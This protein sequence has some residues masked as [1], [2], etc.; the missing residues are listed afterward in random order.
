MSWRVL[1][2][3]DFEPDAQAALRRAGLDVAYIPGIDRQAL[4]KE[5]ASA[6]VLVVRVSTPVDRA[7]LNAGAHLKIVA[8]PGSGVDHIDLRACAERGI[9]VV[10]APGANAESV[11]ELTL[12][13]MLA[14]SR[15]L[16]EALLHTAAGGWDKRLFLGAELQGKTIGLVGRGR[17]GARV[18][19]LAAA[20]GMKVLVSDPAV[21][22]SL[23][24]DELLPAADFVSVHVPLLPAT[25]HLIGAAQLARLRPGAVLMNLSRGGIVDET[26]VLDRPDIL[27]VA[28]VM[29]GEPPAGGHADPRPWPRTPHIGAWTQEAQRR[30]AFET[31]EQIVRLRD[32]W[33]A[34]QA[35]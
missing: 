8:M 1:I 35:G 25:R 5:A 20:F 18:A 26:A 31:V 14:L 24:L 21:P 22:D 29:E 9:R 7:V 27:Y 28:D 10:S 16:P 33:A 17:I 4:L 15:H 34:G 32:E 11:A 6:D 13:L 2:C 12:G 3:D 23:A 19:E 30:A